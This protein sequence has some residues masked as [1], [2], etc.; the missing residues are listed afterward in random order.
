MEKM[1]SFMEIEAISKVRVGQLPYGIQKRVEL[2]REH[3]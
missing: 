2:D 3:V 1:I